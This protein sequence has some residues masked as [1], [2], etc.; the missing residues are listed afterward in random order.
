[1]GCYISTTIV[2]PNPSMNMNPVKTR[3]NARDPVKARTK[4]IHTALPVDETP[5]AGI[6]VEYTFLKIPV[7][8][9]YE[10]S[11]NFFNYKSGETVA[12]SNIAK[13]YSKL[14]EQYNEEF[15]LSTFYQIPG[16]KRLTSALDH[17]VTEQWQGVFWKS[18]DG[19]S[20]KQW[21]L[22]PEKALMQ[23]SSIVTGLIGNVPIVRGTQTNTSDIMDKIALATATGARLI[24]LCLTG[25]EVQ[26]PRT[27]HAMGYVSPREYRIQ[28]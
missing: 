12:S 15:R 17:V 13:K 18:P 26:G 7:R 1:M 9:K 4:S 24:C 11:E 22:R 19:T 6:P 23:V 2:H 20:T 25:E 5:F 8:L 14:T 27:P 28:S 3:T 10:E 16:A 21:E